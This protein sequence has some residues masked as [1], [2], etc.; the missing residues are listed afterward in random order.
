[1]PLSVILQALG[2]KT[3]PNDL[4]VQPGSLH[5]ASNIIIKRDNVVEP[6]RGFKLYGNSFGTNT[7]RAKQLIAYRDRILRHY[8]NKLQFD[9]G[10]GTFTDFNGE[11]EETQEGLRI[12][13][14]EANKNLYFTTAKGIYK[15]AAALSTSFTSNSGFITKAGG[16]KALDFN[17]RLNIIPGQQDGFLTQ[18]SAVAYRVVWGTVDANNN[19]ILGAPSGRVEVYNP[20]LDLLLIDFNRLL[21]SLDNLNQTGSL[22]T[23]GDYVGTLQL[24]QTSTATQL[25]TNL[26]SLVTKLDEDILFADNDGAPTGA[27]L[28]MDTASISTGV[29]TINFAT[30]DPTTYISAGSKIF[31]TDFTTGTG[32]INGAQTVTVVTSNSI[33]FETTATGVVTIGVNATIV[34][35]EFRS[36]TQPSTPSVPETNTQLVALQTYLDSILLVLQSEPSGVID[37]TL[38]TDYID[39]LAL[40]TSTNVILNITIPEEITSNYFLQVYRSA[41]TSADGSINISDIFPN[42]ELQLVY[43]AYP[44]TQELQDGI[45]EVEDTTPDLFRGAF[46]YTNPSTGEGITQA[47]D[48]PPFAKDINRF[49]NYTFYANTKTKHRKS[50]NL[51]GISDIVNSYNNGDNP[52]LTI[53]NGIEENTYNFIIGEQES[54][55]FETVAAAFLE[56]GANPASYFLLNSANNYKKFYVWYNQGS[57]TDPL[58]ANREGIMV[59]L[60]GTE[61]D[62]QVAEKTA[63]VLSTYSYYFI[64]SFL[65]N[66]FTVTNTNV[67]ETDNASSGTSGFTVT[68]LNEGTGEKASQ[69]SAN[70]T[71]IAD[72]GGSLAGDYFS[73]NTA[74][75]KK[76]YYMYF[77]VSGSGSDPAIANKIGIPIELITNDTDSTVATKIVNK[78]NTEYSDFLIAS[79]VGNS[80][81]ITSKAFGPADDAT[82]NTSGFTLNS[83]EQG[84]LQVLV[85]DLDSPAQSVDQTSKSLIRIINKNQT[86]SV[87]FSYLSGAN[88]V[89]GK[90]FIESRE[91]SDTPFYLMANNSDIG[92]SFS[93]SISPDLTITSI[94]TGSPSTML[95]T[96]STNHGLQNLDQ[97]VISGSNSKPSIDGLWQITYVSPTTFRIDSTVQTSGTTG[98][99]TKINSVEV[100]DNEVKPNRIYFSKINQPEA[101]PI[102]NYFD[103][104]AE[105]KEILRIFPLRDSLFVYKE[106]GL[107]RVSGEIAPFSLALFD[108]SCILK[109]PDSLDVS[110]NFLYCWTT[111]GITTTSESGVQIISRDIDVDILKLA[112]SSYVNFKTLTWG[113]GYESDNS[114]T[115][116]TN[117][118]TEDEVATIG[119]RYS[120]LTGTWT[121]IDK[122]NTCGIV[123]PVD[124]KLYMGA[125]DVNKIEQERK[126]FQ[127]TDYADRE[128]DFNLVS[129]KFFKTELILNDVTDVNAGDVLTQDQTL[130]VYTFNSLLKKLD[131][132][133]GINDS[134][135]FTDLQIQSGVILKPALE[136]LATKLDNDL[137]VNDTDYLN[138]IDSKSG[139]ITVIA[140]G[141]PVVITSNN[142]GLQTGRIVNIGGSNCT[143]SIDGQYS[144][145]RIDANN[146][147]IEASVTSPGTS[148]N[149]STDDN[150]FDDI[151]T[152]YNLI[153]SKLNQDT[154]VSFTNYMPITQNTLLEA[155]ITN[156]DKIAKKITLNLDLNF[157]DGPIVI[158]QGI[159][160][161]FRY[162]PNTFG[163]PV[164]WKHIREA[165]I[166]FKNKIFTSGKIRFATDLLPEPQEVDF[167]GQGNGIFGMGTGAFGNGFFG[168]SSHSAPMRT[169]VPRQCQRCISLVVEI[170][171]FVARE[172]FE[173]YGVT[174][175]GED[176][177]SSRAYRG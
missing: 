45:I 48:V 138:T 116:Y 54:T 20:F 113:V 33:S 75:N 158:F 51:I 176:T 32:S 19:L 99:V 62:D 49:K 10:S 131:I 166:L 94:S 8:S 97:I 38:K 177:G 171:C 76:Q 39:V 88:D 61:T 77:I 17:A 157:V 132:D 150:D 50:L 172:K 140:S 82:V 175:T 36:I 81:T 34:S 168:G 122:T 35:N 169:Y 95:I 106:D 74:F 37:P 65:T 27:P 57:V 7:D 120:N 149:F 26:I 165:T 43:E 85:Y 129:D 167:L 92:N 128:L 111:Q 136:A 58:V 41:V 148:G 162:T 1:M 87:Y 80:L 71:T 40:T 115:V 151:K 133:S 156:V 146:F 155:I 31:L 68:I 14:I 112:S 141:G 83:I 42:D 164:T 124:D 53:T 142:H 63:N 91:F 52:S 13:S 143:P 3:S 69:E 2:L 102:V 121:T 12:K 101:V 4:N 109:A 6:R 15:I 107:Y 93:P 72:V 153:I 29:C 135:Y 73:F 89:P 23:D 5:K 64:T 104:A 117:Q 119:Y 174:L 59:L 18:D 118:Q 110:N 170:E 84:A 25:H 56:S 137:G 144:V 163:N 103:V 139:A 100:S 22:I 96:T 160:S 47:N 28:E 16:I 86:E 125:G 152:C 126:D 11:Y 127:R 44:T 98:A 134:N 147:S 60:D 24:D 79:S 30:G 70:F 46:L 173:I 21:N 145:T 130:T 90:M 9:N 161:I 66:T 67:G 114:Y 123:N 108:S 105:N 159:N 55:E 154:G 78:I